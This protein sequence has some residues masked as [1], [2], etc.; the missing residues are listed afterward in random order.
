[1]K[2][3]LLK[4]IKRKY[5]YQY[6]NGMWIINIQPSFP[7]AYCDTTH[8]AVDIMASPFLAFSELI[9]WY[10]KIWRLYGDWGYF[11]IFKL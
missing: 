11:T 1:M 9:P 8:K 7:I 4:K 6:K 10:R 2:T 3:K 5:N